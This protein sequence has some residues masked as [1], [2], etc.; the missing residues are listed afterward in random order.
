VNFD[1]AYQLVGNRWRL[2]GISVNL[3]AAVPT[4]DSKSKISTSSTGGTTTNPKEKI[5]KKVTK[6][7]EPKTSKKK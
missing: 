3:S 1:L 5:T 4:A 7:A 2:F 6:K